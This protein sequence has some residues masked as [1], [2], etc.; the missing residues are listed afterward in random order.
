MR[1]KKYTFCVR[2]YCGKLLE[3]LTVDKSGYL[4]SGLFCFILQVMILKTMAVGN[5]SLFS[6]PYLPLP[7]SE[8]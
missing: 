4:F 7:S 3:N 5:V 1:G 6:F 8:N 2:L